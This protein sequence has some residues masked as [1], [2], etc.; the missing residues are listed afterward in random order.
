MSLTIWN[1][2]IA[3]ELDLNLRDVQNMTQ[4]LSLVIF[5]MIQCSGQ[6]VIPMLVNVKQVTIKL[7]ITSTIAPDTWVYTDEYVIDSKLKEW[8]CGHKSVCHSSGESARDEDDDGFH[9]VH[10]NTMEGS[11]HSFA[12]GYVI[13]GA[14][15]KRNS[16][17]IQG[18]LN[19]CITLESVAKL[20]YPV[21]WRLAPRNP[22]RDF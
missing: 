10:V 8:G 4:Q 12:H 20:P 14:C 2:Q 6:V 18:A 1:S 5:G 16:R 22:L 9:D 19:V 15:L 7:L 17:C 11:G 3:Q 21:F 13:T